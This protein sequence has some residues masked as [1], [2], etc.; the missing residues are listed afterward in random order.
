VHLEPWSPVSF[1]STLWLV[2]LL[3]SF[4]AVQFGCPAPE[5]IHGERL[6]RSLLAAE[7][8]PIR[9]GVSASVVPPCLLRP[10]TQA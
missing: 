10:S 5:E 9:T 4:Q 8:S 1:H 6:A 3:P 2:G 7:S